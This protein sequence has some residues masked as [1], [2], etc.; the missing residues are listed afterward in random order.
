MKTYS[1]K[2]S[3]NLTRLAFL[4]LF[5]IF[6]CV[7]LTAG[8]MLFYDYFSNEGLLWP[9]IVSYFVLLFAGVYFIQYRYVNIPVKITTGPTNVEIK[10]AKR[11]MFYS[12]NK[13]IC[14]WD[15]INKASINIDKSTNRK[16][17]ELDFKIPD[18]TYR[19]TASND[20]DIDAVWTEIN[21]YI[22]NN[23]FP[24]Q[25]PVI[26]KRGFVQG[27]FIRLIAY[28]GICLVFAFALL[29]LFSVPF[30]TTPNILKVV[31]MS[32]FV[33]PFLISFF[34]GKKSNDL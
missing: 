1:L 26:V 30:R 14:T 33:I 32:A 2:L 10:L 12:F 22:N 27:P 15:N 13:I 9:V 24:S 29:L 6:S 4:I 8:I 25:P 7:L 23:S 18:G 17:M 5:P 16:Y 21:Q 28:A 3:R 20:K 34:N 11:N 31:A 19:I